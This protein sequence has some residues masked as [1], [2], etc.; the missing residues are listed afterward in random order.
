MSRPTPLPPEERYL[1]RLAQ[2]LQEAEAAGVA[3]LR[4]REEQRYLLAQRH[5]VVLALPFQYVDAVVEYP[6][7]TPLPCPEPLLV[8]VAY[9]RGELLCVADLLPGDALPPF[10]VVLNTPELRY[11]LVADAI[12]DVQELSAAPDPTSR[13]SVRLQVAP[14]ASQALRNDYHQARLV[15]VVELSRELLRGGQATSPVHGGG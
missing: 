9:H 7:V 15:E 4:Q 11:C 10:L 12:I 8:G 2:L 13:A 5:K 3:P 14:F 1:Q 6:V